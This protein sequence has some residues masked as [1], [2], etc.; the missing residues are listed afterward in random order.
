MAV[1]FGLAVDPDGSTPAP[2]PSRVPQAIEQSGTESRL[3]RALG[4]FGLA[5]NAPG[6]DADRPVSD[7]VG[8]LRRRVSKL[9]EQVGDLLRN[10]S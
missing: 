7:E 10:R 3:R 2:N 8:D 6:P 1:Y 9:E 5:E 4:Y